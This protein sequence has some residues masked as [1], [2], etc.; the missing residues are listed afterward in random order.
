MIF[1]FGIFIFLRR[2]CNVQGQTMNWNENYTETI[3]TEDFNGSSLDRNKWNVAK[4]KRKIGLLIDS[5]AT[6]N[7]NIVR[8]LY[9]DRIIPGKL[10]VKE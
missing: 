8:A 1:V 2:V 4:F 6:L 7:V 5:T 10:V 3:F 9:K